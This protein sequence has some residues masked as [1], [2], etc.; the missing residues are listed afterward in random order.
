MAGAPAR[1]GFGTRLLERGS[2]AALGPGAA[3]ELH[4]EPAGV[5]ATLRF[6]AQ[7]EGGS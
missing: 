5:R 7:P 2:A 6:R 3:V 4:F 1:R